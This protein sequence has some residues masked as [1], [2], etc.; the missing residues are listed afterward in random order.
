M[1]PNS[2]SSFSHF[3]TFLIQF[4]S[5]GKRKKRGYKEEDTVGEDNDMM[6]RRYEARQAVEEE[7][8]KRETASTRKKLPVRG[9]DNE[10]MDVSVDSDEELKM[11]EKREKAVQEKDERLRQKAREKRAKRAANKRAARG[12]A[13][14]REEDG[15]SSRSGSDDE[16]DSSS[17]EE[18]KGSESEEDAMDVDEAESAAN[19]S[20]A[21]KVKKVSLRDDP[22]MAELQLFV[23]RQ[24]EVTQMK[25]KIAKLSISVLEDPEKNLRKLRDLHELLTEEDDVTIRKLIILSELKIFHDIIPSY[26]VVTGADV[27][28]NL[29]K[30][31]KKLR[32]FEHGVLD[33]YQAYLT[34]LGDLLYQ[35]KEILKAKGEKAAAANGKKLKVKSYGKW[36]PSTVDIS[37]MTDAGVEAMLSLGRV[38]A[39]ALGELLV[40]HHHFN[41]R[42]N[43]I[44]ALV[45]ILNTADVE[46]SKIVADSC[47]AL[48]QTDTKGS[49]SLELARTIS[50]L[51]K[52]KEFYVRPVVVEVLKALKLRKPL[53]DGDS[54]FSASKWTPNHKSKKHQSKKEAKE[55]KKDKEVQKELKETEAVE[56]KQDRDSLQTETLKVIFLLYFKILKN[57]KRSPLLPVIL[58][59][60]AH[61][62]HLINLD[63]LLN[64]VE[65]LKE[66]IVDKLIPLESTMHTVITAF[67]AIKL[68]G[69]SLTVDLKDFY[70]HFYPML[71]PSMASPSRYPVL[72][73][74]LIK[75]LE[76]MLTHRRILALERVAAYAKRILTLSLHLP[77]QC[78]I[79]TLIVLNQIFRK[80]PKTQQI[81][82]TEISGMGSYMPEVAD[83]EHCNAFAATAWEFSLL[84]EHVHPSVANL[85]KMIL[86]QD[87]ITE[88][89]AMRM[90]H[91]FD[92]VH[93]GI[94]PS[95]SK[96]R[97]HIFVKSLAKAAKAG[98]DNIYFIQPS[99]LYDNSAFLDTVQAAKD[100][101]AA[102]VT[103]T[104]GLFDE[105]YE[106]LTSMMGFGDDDDDIIS[107]SDDEE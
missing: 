103:K 44:N 26:R 91:Q 85:A 76:L 88:T 78:I 24:Q 33:C 55:A 66:I 69:D 67:Q 102:R 54:I 3:L 71:E 46:L 99:Y 72:L 21:P 1:N 30:D 37:G 63:L 34:T 86:N 8:E 16:S 40:Q 5:K 75:S 45:P 64:L 11:M 15:M 18:E 7:A 22:E 93:N 57:T 9:E 35:G 101:A 20:S 98:R 41:F 53:E 68:Q 6:E 14:K 51:V 77:P 84:T 23:K 59:S 49:S 62:A 90:F 95:M 105:H 12:L 87:P 2:L 97:D 96:P 73:P 36:K 10:L 74:L 29:S 38:A 47:R 43:L 48:F 79:A 13:P 4:H 28:V 27:G 19:G 83:P 39:K 94:V 32:E 82:D 56:S 61:F 58:E 89:N 70:S 17:S 106:D 81:L 60:L 107:Y 42:A 80:Y 50:Q 104:D 65:V 31:V 52:K 100:K 92:F 25:E